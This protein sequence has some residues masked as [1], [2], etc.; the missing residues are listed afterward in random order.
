MTLLSLDDYKGLVA[1][2]A[3][4]AAIEA[5]L[6]ATEEEILDAGGPIGDQTEHAI[7]GYNQIMLGRRALI[8]LRVLE[9][10]GTT[11]RELDSSDYELA[12]SGGYIMRRRGGAHPDSVFRGQ[13]EILYTPFIGINLRKS[14]QAELVAL[15]VGDV[16]GTAAGQRTSE[17][18]GEWT[19]TFST[20]SVSLTPQERRAQLLARLVPSNLVYWTRSGASSVPG[21]AGS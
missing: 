17:R 9:R 11:L 4:D 2:N 15:D 1:T 18:I 3:S 20:T 12:K 10:F 19:E 16:V 6:L 21:P 5:A 14:I 7:G 8:V 13:V